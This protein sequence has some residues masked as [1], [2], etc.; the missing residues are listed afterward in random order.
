MSNE[1]RALRHGYDKN[2]ALNNVINSGTRKILDSLTDVS[3]AKVYYYTIQA[4][5]F[6]YCSLH[7]MLR[8]TLFERGTSHI[9]LGEGVGS[10]TATEKFEETV[11]FYL[12]YEKWMAEHVN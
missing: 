12:F 8:K 3:L 11:P 7:Y 10:V 2:Y 1:K 6:Y 5:E 9:Y 4:Y